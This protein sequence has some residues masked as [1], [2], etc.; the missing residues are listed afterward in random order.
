MYMYTYMHCSVGRE[1][2]SQPLTG[3]KGKSVAPACA[4]T[5]VSCTAMSG[6]NEYTHNTCNH[7]VA[8]YRDNKLQSACCVTF[9]ALYTCSVG[10]PVGTGSSGMGCSVGPCVVL[11]TSS[12]CLCL[13]SS[14]DTRR[15]CAHRKNTREI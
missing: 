13:C 3:L 12:S 14:I 15:A 4:R 1:C 8:R 2:N 7:S 9:N 10:I 11:L 5:P 6:E